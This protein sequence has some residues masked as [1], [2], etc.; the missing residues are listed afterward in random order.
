MLLGAEH[1]KGSPQVLVLQHRHAYRGLESVGGEIWR[2][3]QVEARADVRHRRR[4]PVEHDRPDDALAVLKLHRV[5]G[6]REPERHD[7]L[8]QAFGSRAREQA[9]CARGHSHRGFQSFLL[10]D[11]RTLRDR[12]QRL[13][14]LAQ[15]V[16]RRVELR[17]L[18]GHRL[19]DA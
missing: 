10:Q 5:D 1:R 6:G 2:R 13:R 14:D 17:R 4:P 8:L 11:L 19:E 7:H 3:L 18:A 16:E 15:R 12:G 9:R